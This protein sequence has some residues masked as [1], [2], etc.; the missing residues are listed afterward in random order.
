M[1]PSG[2]VVHA[3]A[4]AQHRLPVAPQ[5]SQVPPMPIMAPK[6]LR[7]AWQFAP[8]QQAAPLAPQPA[9]QVPVALALVTEQ[10]RPALQTLLSQQA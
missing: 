8:G 2:I 6:Q 7:P 1:Q 9:P 4:P 10:P 5:A 3:I